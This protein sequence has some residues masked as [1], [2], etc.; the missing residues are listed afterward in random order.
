MNG[1]I[2]DPI[3]GLIAMLYGLHKIPFSQ[4]L[5]GAIGAI[6]LAMAQQ[7]YF[8]MAMACKSWAVWPE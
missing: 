3:N 1:A 7:R 5:D 4:G 6:K 8:A 2:S